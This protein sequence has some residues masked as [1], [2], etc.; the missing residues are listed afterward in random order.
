[1]THALPLLLTLACASDPAPL[2]DAAVSDA[3]E[4]QGEWAVVS[5]SIDGRD[6]TP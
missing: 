2:P 3:G 1:M 6:G 5:V 4:L